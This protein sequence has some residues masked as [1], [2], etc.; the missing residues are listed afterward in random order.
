MRF[1]FFLLAVAL[2]PCFSV[3]AQKKSTPPP[4]QTFTYVEQMPEFPG[5]NDSMF[6]FLS[7]NLRY[8]D[9]AVAQGIEGRV[10]VK[11]LISQNG[12][13]DSAVVLRGIGYGC[14]EEAARVIKSMPRWNPGMLNGK[15]T[16]V[17]YTL[18]VTF[19][20]EDDIKPAD[21]SAHH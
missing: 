20:L 21:T 6:R 2:T 10:T 1:L 14:D 17:Y 11:F 9:S 4:S 12:L 13:I 5:G 3:F 16:S 7:A 15:P 19:R 18:P 8:P